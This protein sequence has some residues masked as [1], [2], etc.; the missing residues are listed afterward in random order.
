MFS[1]YVIFLKTFPLVRKDRGKK[2]C[3]WKQRQNCEKAHLN[4]PIS[5]CLSMELHLSLQQRVLRIALENLQHDP[6]EPLRKVKLGPRL[7]RL[8]E[9]REGP[10][11]PLLLGERDGVHDALH[12]FANVDEAH[13]GGGEE[14]GFAEERQR[15]V[16]R[17]GVEVLQNPGGATRCFGFFAVFL[18]EACDVGEEGVICGRNDY[19]GEVYGFLGLLL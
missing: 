5:H 3:H 4:A 7:A 12:G 10:P 17:E 19:L 11:S 8:D 16:A 6:C 9:P 13:G 18:D 15:G 1:V 14:D 2:Q